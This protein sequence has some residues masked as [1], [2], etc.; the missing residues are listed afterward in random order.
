MNK[1]QE[2]IFKSFTQKTLQTK[3]EVTLISL[4][5]YKLFAE[6]IKENKDFYRYY[7]KMN[8]TFPLKDNYD[9]MWKHIIKPYYINKGIIDENIMKLRFVCYQA[10]FTNCLGKWVEND[11]DL[12]IEEIANILKECI[13]L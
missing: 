10:G 12:S 11:C 9:H 13:T 6:H 7:F 4:S 2:D 5:S 3:E 1:I 8:T